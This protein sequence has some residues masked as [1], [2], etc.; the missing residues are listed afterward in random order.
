MAAIA[1]KSIWGEGDKLTL[2]ILSKLPMKGRW[3][4]LAAGDGRYVQILLG[5]VDGV[6]AADI[7]RNALDA[8]SRRASGISGTKLVIKPFNMT[9]KFPFKDNEFDGILCTGTLHLLQKKNISDVLGEMDRVLRPK[10]TIVLDFSTHVNRYFSKNKT[11]VEQN[12]K[13]DPILQ[14][15]KNKKY[16]KKVYASTFSDDLTKVAKYGWSTIGEFTLLILKKL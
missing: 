10:G 8:L 11:N 9:D 3:L 5:K 14:F 1:R 4:D 7:D 16:E 2:Q 12:Y 6:V 13:I 15:F